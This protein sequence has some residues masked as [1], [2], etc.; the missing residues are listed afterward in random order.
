MPRIGRILV[1][2]DDASQLEFLRTILRADG[3]EVASATSAG[4][5]LAVLDRGDE[6]D[7]ILSDLLM[8]GMDGRALLA[9]VLERRPEVPVIILTAHASVDS[10]VDLLQAGAWH[11]LAKP[12]KVSE[13]RLVVRRAREATETNRELARLRRRLNVPADVVGVSRV[14]RDVLEAAL[15]AAPTT[16]PVLITGEPGTGKEVVA[17]AIHAASGRNGFLALNCAAIPPDR[18][19]VELFGAPRGLGESQAQT[20]G[21]A[22]ARGGTLFLDDVTDVPLASQPALARF[23][24][25]GRYTAGGSETHSD[26]RVIAATSRDPAAEA[27]TG[28]FMPELLAQLDIVRLHLPPLRERA[29]DI[30]ALATHLLERLAARFQLERAELAPDALA[31]ITSYPW[32]G[33]IRELEN[34][35]ARAVAVRGGRAIGLRDLPPAVAGGTPTTI[36]TG[37][38]LTLEEVER[39]HILQVLDRAGGNKLK[40][41]EMLG[42]DR[43]TLHRKLKQLQGLH[44]AGS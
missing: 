23:V 5:A 6:V 9:A 8:P 43:S 19:E 3:W 27:Q 21:A 26:A 20:G 12:P 44:T 28:R 25:T 39:R 14:M 33:N 38:I 4:T 36:P 15:R 40:A 30:P 22:T 1:V 16:T 18:F 29:V 42:I 24:Q 11:Y 35:L 31:A 41:A 17:R 37:P 7:V 34:A 32:P 2:D 10:A 13:L